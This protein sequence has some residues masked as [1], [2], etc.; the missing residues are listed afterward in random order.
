FPLGSADRSRRQD[1]RR[2]LDLPARWP[3]ALCQPALATHR[4]RLRSGGGDRAGHRCGAHPAPP[5]GQ[6]EAGDRGSMGFH[7]HPP[8]YPPGGASAMRRRQHIAPILIA[9]LVLLSLALPS[10]ALASNDPL[11]SGTTTIAIASSFRHLLAAHGVNLSAAAPAARKG[12]AFRLP[13]AKG[14]VDPTAS[15]LKLETTGALTFTR[16]HRQVIFRH[17]NLK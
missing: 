1:F 4:S 6:L 5:R 7:G 3:R 2:A 10:A 15:R 14:V 12:S 11:G 16:G 13:L 8:S 9:P 17:L